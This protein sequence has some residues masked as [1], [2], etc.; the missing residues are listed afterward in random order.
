MRTHVRMHTSLS[1]SVAGLTE[2][3]HPRHAQWFRVLV[4]AAF[5]GSVR[6]CV[7]DAFSSSS[8]ATAHGQAEKAQLDKARDFQKWIQVD[9]PVELATRIVAWRSSLSDDEQAALEKDFFIA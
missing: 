2:V 5:S 1:G 4:S 8:A 3:R 6:G 9:Y 7:C